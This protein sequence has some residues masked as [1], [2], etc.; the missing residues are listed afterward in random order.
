VIVIEL[1]PDWFDMMAKTKVL[2]LH[3]IK[4]PPSLKISQ[5]IASFI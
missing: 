5:G 3:G 2:P 4:F 1:N